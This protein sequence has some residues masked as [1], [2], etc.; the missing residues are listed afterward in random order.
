M[1]TLIGF[2]TYWLLSLL[3]AAFF[4]WVL[5]LLFAIGV[6]VCGKTGRALGVADHGGIVWDEIVA[7]VLVLG[8][9]PPT[10]TW[11]IAAFL[12]FRL[13]D[14]WKPFPIGYVD[15]TIK[16]GFGVMLDDLLAAGYAIAVIGVARSY[17]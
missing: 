17:S 14:I 7:F 6:W 15:G 11:A 5:A 13:F 8:L 2:P 1:G 16:G 9:S 12:L 4:W 10:A 3:P